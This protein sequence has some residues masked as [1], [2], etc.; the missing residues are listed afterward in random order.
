[1]KKAFTYICLC[2]AVVGCSKVDLVSGNS[3]EDPIVFDNVQTKAVVSSADEILSMGVF[4]QMNLGTEGDPGYLDYIMLL[5]NEF[6]QRS[7]PDAD[8]TYENTRY[9]VDDREYHF[10]AVWPYSGNPDS[11]VTNASSVDGDGAFSYRVTFTTPENADQEL[12]TATKSER[13]VAGIPSP[14]SVKFQF[15]HQLT[16]VNF[17]IWRNGAPESVYDRIKVKPRTLQLF[18]NFKVFSFFYNP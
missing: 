15:E 2:A 3:D 10:F 5:D 13:T 9:W 6:V 8:W 7:G 17:K 4:A 14:S 18:L 16:N 1:M 12:L 11:P